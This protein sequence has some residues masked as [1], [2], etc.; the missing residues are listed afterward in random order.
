MSDRSIFGCRFVVGN[1]RGKGC[2]DGKKKHSGRRR[3]PPRRP[4]VGPIN[5]TNKSDPAR[6]A[7]QSRSPGEVAG[8]TYAGPRSRR[9]VLT[10]IPILL[11]AAIAIVCVPM[12][13]Y[14]A[15]GSILDR[16][17][18]AR[19]KLK[20]FFGYFYS[21]KYNEALRVAQELAFTLDRDSAEYA[22]WLNNMACAAAWMG[23]FRTAHTLLHPYDRRVFS[24]SGEP[25]WY[26][27][28]IG[29]L[30]YIVYHL[31]RPT[32]RF[33]RPVGRAVCDIS[34]S[35]TRPT[36]WLQ[37]WSRKQPE[38]NDW[39]TLLV[40]PFGVLIRLYCRE[41]CYREAFEYCELDIRCQGDEAQGSRLITGMIARPAVESRKALQYADQVDAELAAPSSA[42]HMDAVRDLVILDLAG[43]APSSN[44]SFVEQA[45]S[46]KAEYYAY[47]ALA[48]IRYGLAADESSPLRREY[49]RRVVQ[50]YKDVG[51]EDSEAISHIRQIVS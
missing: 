21:D 32:Y 34:R 50:S 4:A 30:A 23:D 49:G 2:R 6:L 51:K 24:R 43:K 19:A 44:A 11:A 39:I 8:H 28:L 16:H 42:A 20:D 38:G 47:A 7:P 31:G 26:G 48:D 36:Q 22:M 10:E 25:W 13:T 37:M 1:P 35:K 12:Q 3:G 40:P 29:N 46:A 27:V 41:G 33:I 14:D 18:Q 17:G 45:R 15:V 5:Q 9:E